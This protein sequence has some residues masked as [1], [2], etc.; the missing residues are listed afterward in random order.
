MLVRWRCTFFFFE[1]THLRGKF[2]FFFLSKLKVHPEVPTVSR[3]ESGRVGTGRAR[4]FS[5]ITGRFELP[6]PD[7]IVT[8]L[9]TVLV[10]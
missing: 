2:F 4:R 5:N 8:I 10:M 1:A 3:I 9:A 6:L 7:P